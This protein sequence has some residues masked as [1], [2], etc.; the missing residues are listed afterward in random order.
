MCMLFE[1]FSS[2]FGSSTHTGLAGTQQRPQHVANE[3]GMFY[4][5]FTLCGQLSRS[6]GSLIA[7]YKDDRRLATPVITLA[8]DA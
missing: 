8:R 4:I 2:H 7:F 6:G 1:L 3:S 5:Q